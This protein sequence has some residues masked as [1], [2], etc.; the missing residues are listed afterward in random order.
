MTP[1]R[2][3]PGPGRPLARRLQARV[4]RLVNI[5]VRVMLG[6]P[7]ATPPAGRLMLVCY[8]GRRTG[9]AYR[10][11]VSYV[12]D[13]RVLLTPGGGN[14]KLSLSDG[15][16]VR[17]RLRG[18]DISARPELI[19]DPAQVHVL[20]E[21]MMAVNPSLRLFAGIPRG[22][23]G[24]LD[25]DRLELAVRHGFRVVRWHPAQPLPDR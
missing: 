2:P 5:P 3:A 15:E 23:D 22:S 13:G 12:R 9:R 18:R 11:P 6:L 19:G 14:W 17:L 8:T 1:N 16:P 24:R 20:L 10:Q 7:F 21:R 25:R 4:F